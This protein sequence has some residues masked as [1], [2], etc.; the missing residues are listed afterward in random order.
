MSTPCRAFS[1]C[2]SH[3]FSFVVWLSYMFIHLIKSKN[4][5]LANR[6]DPCSFYWGQLGTGRL[7]WCDILYFKGVTV[8]V[9]RLGSNLGLVIWY[10]QLIL[11]S[12]FV[13]WITI[14]TRCLN[15]SV[16]DLLSFRVTSTDCWYQIKVEMFSQHYVPDS[17]HQIWPW[18]RGAFAHLNKLLLP[19]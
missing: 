7:Y 14:S 19:T 3:Q 9:V 17:Q 11:C 2:K 1:W 15:V 6:I 5:K 16:G 4:V 18:P 8:T 13:K 12:V 10:F